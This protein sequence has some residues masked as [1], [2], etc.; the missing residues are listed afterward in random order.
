MPT[1]YEEAMLVYYGSRQMTVDLAGTG[2]R[3]ETFQRYLT[4]VRVQ[5]T[6]QPHN[7]QDVLARLIRDFGST[8][9]FYYSFGRVGLQ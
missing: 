3:P 7:Q 2:I 5:S 6:L 8:Y 9:F 1:L 4:F